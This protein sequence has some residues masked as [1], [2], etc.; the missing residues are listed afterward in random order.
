MHVFEEPD[1]RTV[2][3]GKAQP[4]A[5]SG[6]L[7]Q[8]RAISGNLHLS[9]RY[10]GSSR[11]EVPGDAFAT[12][13]TVRWYSVKSGLRRKDAKNEQPP[14]MPALRQWRSVKYGRQ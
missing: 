9:Q 4:R 6:N 12:P 13:R 11:A 1:S 7:G 3:L 2:W 5:T 8:S 10:F 14:P